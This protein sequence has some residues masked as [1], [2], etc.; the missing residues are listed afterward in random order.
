MTARLVYRAK[1]LY[2]D[3][4]VL[5]I[6][7]WRLPRLSAERSH[8]LKYRMHYGRADGSCIVRYDNE[9]GKGDHRHIGQR[10]EPYGFKDIETL[11]DD[12]FNDVAKARGGFHD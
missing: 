12:F 10:E 1:E 9:A 11:L 6:V 8:A 7:I 4:C 3:G 5:E 2:P